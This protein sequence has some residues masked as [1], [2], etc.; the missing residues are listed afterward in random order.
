MLISPSTSLFF[1]FFFFRFVLFLGPEK[2][3]LPVHAHTCHRYKYGLIKI[4]PSWEYHLFLEDALAAALL[5]V[6]LQTC[7]SL[8]CPS[9]SHSLHLGAFETYTVL[10]VIY[11]F[12]EMV[13]VFLFLFVVQ[14]QFLKR[15]D[16]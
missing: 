13:F 1:F 3:L 12:V 7:L 15:R 8:E 5:E 6:Q 9:S 4:A 10:K 14:E 2:V 11:S 16:D